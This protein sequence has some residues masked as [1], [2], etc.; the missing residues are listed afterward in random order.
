VE[1]HTLDLRTAHEIAPRVWLRG[2]YIHGIENFDQ[3]SIDHLGDFHADSGNAGVEFRFPSL[4]S[5][6]VNYDYQ[7]RD[8]GVKMQRLNLSLLQAF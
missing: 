7:S 2:G 8:G 1:S 3:F 6:L 4:T 5:I